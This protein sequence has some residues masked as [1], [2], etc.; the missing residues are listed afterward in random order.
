LVSENLDFLRPTYVRVGPSFYIDNPKPE[1]S[2]FVS[3]ES[4]TLCHPSVFIC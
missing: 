1:V 3:R 4:L 2:F